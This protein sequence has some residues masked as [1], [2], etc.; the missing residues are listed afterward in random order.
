MDLSEHELVVAQLREDFERTIAERA[1][2]FLLVRRKCIGPAH[3]FSHVIHEAI[4]LFRDGYFVSCVMAT[5]A[6]A[7]GIVRL[8]AER[9]LGTAASSTKKQELVATLTASGVLSQSF[10][11]AFMRIQRSW[12]NDFHH[13]NPTIANLDVY[14]IAEQNIQD[15][16]VMEDEVFGFDFADG[17]AI[18][19]KVPKYWDFTSEGDVKAFVNFR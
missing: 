18:I 4:D 16:R 3:H 13:M 17:G 12:R 5:Q 1:E 14:Q 7:E 19:P 15:I 11:D 2:R 6:L 10:A 8:V 9:N